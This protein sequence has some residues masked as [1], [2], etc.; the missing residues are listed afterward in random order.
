MMG[1]HN[2]PYVFRASDARSL[3]QEIANAFDEASAREHGNEAL[4]ELDQRADEFAERLTERCVRR[5]ARVGIAALSCAVG[6]LAIVALL[7]FVNAPLADTGACGEL[8]CRANGV[9]YITEAG[10]IVVFLGESF[11]VE[12]AI[13]GDRV[14]ALAPRKELE[15][16]N[17]IRL[18][19]V[20]RRGSAALVWGNRL[21]RPLRFD[22]TMTTPRREAL[23][24]TGCVL[25][26]K[27]YTYEAWGFAVDAV[28]ISN[29][30]FTPA[31]GAKCE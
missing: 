31:A 13:E 23:T 26:P 16:P 22:V 28:E 8:P 7:V 17:T 21:D 4:A 25:T 15:L 24:T 12:L 3:T 5:G 18:E 30:Q 19:L 1:R 29:F 20:Q 27:H 14:V 11:S 2:I 6:L 10:A 9:P